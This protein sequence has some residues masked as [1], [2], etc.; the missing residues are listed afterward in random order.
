[1]FALTAVSTAYNVR[2]T[3]MGKK[4]AKSKTKR[5][6]ADKKRQT[7]K[8]E[9][10]QAEVEAKEKSQAY[11]KQQRARKKMMSGGKGRASTI[12]TPS[13]PTGEGATTGSSA[14]ASGAA[15]KTMLGL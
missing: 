12:K 15:Q 14:G 8:L 6:R 7:E 10:E 1:M 11:I 3:E 5:A 2:E 4:E 13:A 9:Q